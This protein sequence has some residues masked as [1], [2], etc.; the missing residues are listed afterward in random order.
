MHAGAGGGGGGVTVQLCPALT[1]VPLPATLQQ[2]SPA[3]T[4]CALQLHAVVVAVPTTHVGVVG[5]V[6]TLLH[7]A[8][9]VFAAMFG[10]NAFD[11]LNA[12]ERQISVAGICGP[13]TRGALV[14]MSQQQRMPQ[15]LIAVDP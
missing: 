1:T 14:F 6:V 13:F 2:V 9:Q 5:G 3:F 12:F 10:S 8:A 15:E 11:S 7:I 4:V